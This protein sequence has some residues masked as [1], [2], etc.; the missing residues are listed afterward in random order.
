VFNQQFHL[1]TTRALLRVPAPWRPLIT[2]A[3][4]G[5]E[6]FYR[7]K[8]WPRPGK[9]KPAASLQ[10]ELFPARPDKALQIAGKSTPDPARPLFDLFP[11]A[12]S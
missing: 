11:E 12:Y 8:F 2:I 4:V 1:R 10:L 6:T 7:P 5:E 9:Q 3:A